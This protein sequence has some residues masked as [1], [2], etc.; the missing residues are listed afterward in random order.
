MSYRELRKQ[1]QTQDNNDENRSNS[2]RAG[3][4]FSP[5][6]SGMLDEQNKTTTSKF[7]AEHERW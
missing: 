6:P 1:Q 3:F 2:S 7:N 4:L 5:S